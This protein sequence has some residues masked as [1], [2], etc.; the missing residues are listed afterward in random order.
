MEVLFESVELLLDSDLLEESP[1]DDS[2]FVVESD[3]LL[4]PAELELDLESVT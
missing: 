2:V 4:L 1:E 3:L